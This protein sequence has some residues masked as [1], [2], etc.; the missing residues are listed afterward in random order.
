MIEALPNSAAT[1][2]IK[3]VLAVDNDPIMLKF[4]VRI[5]E[6]HGLNIVTAN[7]AVA[8]IDILESYTPDLFFIDLVMPNIDGKA[9]CQIIR[10]KTKFKTTPIVIL[11][12]IAA[13]ESINTKKFGANICVAKVVY[14]KMEAMINQLLAE[15]L[16]L[17]DPVLSNR[18]LGVDDLA[19]RNITS[20]L[21]IINRHFRVMLDSII[22]GIIEFDQNHRIIYANPMAL[23]FFDLSSEEMLGRHVNQLFKEESGNN[24]LS[25]LDVPKSKSDREDNPL[26]ISI[27]ERILDVRVVL[28]DHIQN[29][30]VIILDDITA[31]EA[32]QKKLLMANE[33]LKTLSRID[34][35]TQVFN[36]RYFD[37]IFH[38]EWARLKREK[39][40]LSLIIFDVDY[41]KSYNDSYGHL[42]GDQ[43]LRDI[44]QAIDTTVHRT[45]DIVARY[46][47][48]EFVL[49]LPNTPLDG[50]LHLAE[51]IRTGIERLR[52]IHQKS[53]VARHVTVTIG[54]GN[55]I[56]SD[57]LTENKL[58]RLADRALYKAKLKG[59]N[60][61]VGET[62]PDH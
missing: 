16:L 56:P 59:R 41:F 48:D 54:A 58:I 55:G 27:G 11:S 12:A 29:T 5:H 19:P 37:E 9:L 3:N 18:V 49:S 31:S 25:L 60:C 1:I 40:E 38:K 47:G 20:E 14:S 42:H 34:G 8:A 61:V 15:P 35:L 2:S 30:Q 17:W 6:K 43:C 33:K 53:P 23:D 13:E 28:S 26:K 62:W 45:A 50:A 36:R 7:D 44:A 10:R 32:A 21:L 57:S 51:Q 39:G 46:G 4:L 52:I 22:S 24:I